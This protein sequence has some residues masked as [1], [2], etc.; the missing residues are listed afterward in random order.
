MPGTIASDRGPQWSKAGENGT[1]ICTLLN[2]GI[3][4][5]I[6]LSLADPPKKEPLL[7]AASHFWSDALIV[8]LFGHGPMTPSLI[9]VYMLIGLDIT[10]TTLA[11][12]LRIKTKQKFEFRAIGGWKGYI[13]KNKKTGAVTDRGHAAFLLVWFD[14]FIFCGASCGPTSNLQ[15]IAECLANDIQMPLGKYL[16]R[17]VYSMLHQ[18]II[19]FLRNEPI[20]NLGGP[21]WFL[22]AWLNIY[23]SRAAK[24]PAFT[25]FSFPSAD[26]ADSHRQCTSLDEVALAIEGQRTTANNLA[27]CFKAFYKGFGKK[28]SI[29][30]FPYLEMDDFEKP[31]GFR[32][33][34]PLANVQS[35]EILAAYIKPCILPTRISGVTKA[36]PASYEFYHPSICACQLGFG[37]LPISL[38][39]AT[40]VLPRLSVTFA[41]ETSW[42]HISAATQIFQ[43]FTL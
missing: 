39:L 9:D 34:D 15:H 2:L 25:S 14:H 26:S 24:W 37:Q 23:T 6:N 17:A 30:R 22:L 4:H 8:F 11:F 29:L 28:N 10:S 3:S 1:T 7:I 18:S 5:A 19:K 27:S 20:D 42:L 21:W 41:L 38:S 32:A 16:L 40:G 35:A 12:S 36:Q 43:L 31:S 13:N 33:D